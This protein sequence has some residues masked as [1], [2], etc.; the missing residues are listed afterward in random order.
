ME[1]EDRSHYSD[2]LLAGRPT[3]RSSSPGRGEI[4]LFS[5]SSRPVLRFTQPAIQWVPR[6]LHP[7]R[8]ADHSPPNSAEVKNTLIYTSI[9][10]YSFMA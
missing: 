9:P 1:P 5:T 3:V 6:A 8:E 2:L 10:P 4:F 7:G